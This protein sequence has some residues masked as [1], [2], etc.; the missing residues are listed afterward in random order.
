MIEDEPEILRLNE[1]VLN[2]FFDGKNGID[3]IQVCK[4]MTVKE[5]Q[6]VIFDNGQELDVILLDINMPDGD[7]LSL[8][9][10]IRQ[11]TSASVI[12]L[13]ARNTKSDVITG[14]L[15]GSD[16]YIVKPYDVDELCARV[17][18]AFRRRQ[19]RDSI[20]K[21]GRFSLDIGVSR[22]Y[23]DGVDLLLTPKQFA[24]LLLFMKNEGR[25]LSPE[26][27]YQSI[28]KTGTSGDLAA[29]WKQISNLKAKIEIADM[30]HI[31]TVRGKGYVFEISEN[32]RS[33]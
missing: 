8:L 23:M 15:E 2:R 21:N 33:V 4:A 17:L 19:Q 32:F 28:W 29:L 27:I 24:L 1:R 5:A 26:F 6:S 30:V 7:G 20:F 18:A 16:D 25:I 9:N 14:L 3:E 11:M 31:S 22:A 12:I 13:S 10:Q